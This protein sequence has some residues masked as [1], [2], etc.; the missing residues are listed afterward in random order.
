MKNFKYLT[1]LTLGVFLLLSCGDDNPISQLEIEGITVENYPR[2]DGSTSTGPLNTLIACKVLGIDYKWMQ[3]LYADGTYTIYPDY[4]QAPEGFFGERVKVSQTHQSFINLIDNE[5]DLIL[6]A[7]KM[8]PD[9]KKYAQSKGVSLIET[10]VAL[11]AFVFIVN[12][13]NPIKNLSIKQIQDIYTGKITNW[14]EVGEKAN[15]INP[16]IRDAN[17]GSQELMET[18]VMAGI[19]MPEWPTL[20]ISSM[21]MV[22]TYLLSD[23]NGLCYTVHYYKE[24]MV[25]EK[26]IKSISVDGVFPQKKTIQNR[27]YPFTTEVYAI[28]SSDVSTSSTTYKLYQSLLS[29]DGQAVIAESGYVPI[30]S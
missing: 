5:V 29:E 7:R 20:M 8:S 2:V 6:S 3:N 28:I 13:K 26:S 1:I 10:P 21:M 4:N 27:S 23:I 9:E 11:D 14:K 16:Y 15:P 24:Q 25:R 18:L 12:E 17:S 22:F 30:G 19:E